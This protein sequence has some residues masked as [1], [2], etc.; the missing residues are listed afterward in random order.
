VAAALMGPVRA[1]LENGKA[2]PYR[3]QYTVIPE[4]G[5]Y[6]CLEPAGT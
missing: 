5:E 2:Y 6:V 4:Q 3:S 1:L